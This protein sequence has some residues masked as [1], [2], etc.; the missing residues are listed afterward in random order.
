ML[1]P[2]SGPSYESE[3]GSLACRSCGSNGL[4]LGTC[5]SDMSS[6]SGQIV[7]GLGNFWQNYT[8]F[9][10]VNVEC[11]RPLGGSLTC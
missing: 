4:H 8:G 2:T 6:L 9:G 3:Q 11:L 7:P 1:A 5:I 10:S